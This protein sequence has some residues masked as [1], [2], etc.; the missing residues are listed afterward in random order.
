MSDPSGGTSSGGVER[1]R[2][3]A[4]ADTVLTEVGNAILRR[5]PRP[6]ALVPDEADL[7][8]ELRISRR[9]A[10][11]A[12]ATLDSAGVIARTSPADPPALADTDGDGISRLLRLVVRA[13]A[14]FETDDVIGVRTAIERSAAAR[15]AAGATAGDLAALRAIVARMHDPAVDP[16]EFRALDTAFHIRVAAA[17]AGALQMPL[18]QGLS[19]VIG[20]QMRR[21]FARTADWRATARRLAGEHDQ[22]LSIINGGLE[23]EA[24]DFVEAHIQDFYRETPGRCA[25]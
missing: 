23:A 12:L 19:D 8:E 17:S 16:D 9:S 7:T 10:R 13:G 21:A 6:G 15:A 4:P 5:N 24:A 2:V 11:R 14:A 18:L 22:L 3:I 1:P 25:T 20:G